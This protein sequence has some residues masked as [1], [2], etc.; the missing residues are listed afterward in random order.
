MTVDQI[1]A[2][3]PIIASYLGSIKHI[4]AKD[5]KTFAIEISKY[6]DSKDQKRNKK[7]K[8]DKKYKK[9][10]KSQKGGEDGWQGSR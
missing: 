4:C 7:G 5:S 6:I 2:H 1:I 10:Q 8:K 9:K 3:D